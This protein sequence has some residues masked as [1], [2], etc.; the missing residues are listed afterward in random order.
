VKQNPNFACTKTRKGVEAEPTEQARVLLR[1]RER[2]EMQE[3]VSICFKN[4]IVL[5][6]KITGEEK[7][8]RRGFTAGEWRMENGDEI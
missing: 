8:R 3:E 6:K 1:E 4:R 5:N 2:G 7:E